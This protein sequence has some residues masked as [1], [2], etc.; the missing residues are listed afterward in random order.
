[1]KRLL[2]LFSI[3][4]LPRGSEL[5]KTKNFKVDQLKPK[6]P[7]MYKLN[8]SISLDRIREST[9]NYIETNESSEEPNRSKSV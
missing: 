1:M 3:K 4:K 6:D 8:R 5:K 9:C 2:N 7:S